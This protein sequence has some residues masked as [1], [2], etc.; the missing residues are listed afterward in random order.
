MLKNNML[1]SLLFIAY[2]ALF[3]VFG[4]YINN[5]FMFEQ[6]KLLTFD[7]FDHYIIINFIVLTAWVVTSFLK[8][9][10]LFK[11]ANFLVFIM[12]AMAFAALF[13]IH[14]EARELLDFAHWP[15][16]NLYEVSIVLYA[17]TTAMAFYFAKE[18]KKF[19]L[20]MFVLLILELALI[21]WLESL[22]QNTYKELMPALKSYWLPSHVA[23]NFLGYGAFGIAGMAGLM[24]LVKHYTN[25]G[26]LPSVKLAES[27]S[28][29]A[30]AFGFPLFTIAT[31]LGSVWA[32]EAWGAYWS[33]DPKET[34]A[35]IVWLIYATYLHLRVTKR[36]SEKT[37]CL[38]SFI[39]F[40]ATAFCFLGVNLFL[41]GLHS[42]G[43]LS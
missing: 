19:T 20:F 15:L 29:K 13:I 39:A 25:I 3:A 38:I 42:Y 35:L 26:M 6:S 21:T 5:N 24:G 14:F 1:L 41:S 33:W 40:F 36:V 17:V 2:T 30:I 16:S 32:Y 4:I 10:A 11:A 22:G 9:E 18:N 12:S 31:I 37:L 7:F 43:Q 23:A 28:F 34:W 8:K 27:I